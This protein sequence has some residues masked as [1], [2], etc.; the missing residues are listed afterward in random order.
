MRHL[1]TS[2]LFTA[3]GTS[4]LLTASIANAGQSGGVSAIPAGVYEKGDK[5]LIFRTNGTHLKIKSKNNNLIIKKVVAI[6]TPMANECISW[7]Y[8]GTERTRPRYEVGKTN[9]VKGK[10]NPTA[11][12]LGI[13]QPNGWKV[14]S[15]DILNF[16]GY[17]MDGL[18][19]K[20]EI[21]LGNGTKK[22]F[23]LTKQ[24]RTDTTRTG[25]EFLERN[26]W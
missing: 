18:L 20:V 10:K 25:G 17:C 2:T 5:D 16:H 26:V 15:G 19:H 24:D 11:E 12:Q 4:L 6:G 14:R 23:V 22:K 8:G 21:T 3:I 7:T 13:V 1:V 9:I